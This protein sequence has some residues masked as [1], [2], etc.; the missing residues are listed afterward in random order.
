MEQDT[1]TTQQKDSAIIKEE[2]KGNYVL[3]T[4]DN[5]ETTRIYTVN[6]AQNEKTLEQLVL[7]S[8]TPEDKFRKGLL[9][10]RVQELGR[11]IIVSLE[12]SREVSLA[13]TKLQEALLLCGAVLDR[14][15]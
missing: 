14:E 13:L 12:P 8:H 2:N 4:L 1:S 15:V 11:S 7:K 10:A 6:N 3:V 5:N 9:T